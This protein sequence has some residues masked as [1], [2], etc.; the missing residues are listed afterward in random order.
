MR[1]RALTRPERTGYLPAL[2]LSVQHVSTSIREVYFDR[3]GVRAGT[4]GCRSYLRNP[5][6]TGRRLCFNRTRELEGIDA[7]GSVLSYDIAFS[8]IDADASR[9]CTRTD[10]A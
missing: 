2:R 7:A 3:T 1:C 8:I 4:D 5:N 10:I 6:C 9:V